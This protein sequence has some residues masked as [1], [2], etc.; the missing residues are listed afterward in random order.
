MFTILIAQI[1]L[2]LSLAARMDAL[3][4]LARVTFY[5]ESS[6]WSVLVDRAHSL[7]TVTTELLSTFTGWSGSFTNQPRVR[8]PAITKHRGSTTLIMPHGAQDEQNIQARLPFS[9]PRSAPSSYLP[10]D[11]CLGTCQTKWISLTVF[12][13]GAC[14][15]PQATSSSG[16]VTPIETPS[17]T[18]QI[19]IHLRPTRYGPCVQQTASVEE[20]SRAMTARAAQ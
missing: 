15:S 18:T 19:R 17:N 9:P 4:A 10:Q 1:Q 16:T 11:L 3:N 2:A 20:I 12:L 7:A 14:L 6:S 5:P 8:L 13:P